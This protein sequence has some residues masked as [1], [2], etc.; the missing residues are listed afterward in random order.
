MYFKQIGNGPSTYSGTTVVNNRDVTTNTMSAGITLTADGTLPITLVDFDAV[1]DNGSVILSWRTLMESNSDHF[2]IE[3]SSNGGSNWDVVGK[4]A[5]QGNSSIP[6]SYSFTDANPGSGT[7]QYRV[8]GYDKDGRSTL[9]PIKV[10]R[11]TPIANVSVYP[12]PAKDYVNVSLPASESGM[13]HIRLISQT[14]QLLVEKNVT[15]A[16]GTVQ[17][18]SVSSYPT[19]NYLVQVISTDGTRQ[20]SKV[21]ISRN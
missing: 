13:V 1:V 11:T 21:V 7:F 9:S 10:V 17:S 15:G 14:G 12:N 6:V 16:G 4:V 19:G 18:F 20:V 3:R 5:A 8:H 2:D